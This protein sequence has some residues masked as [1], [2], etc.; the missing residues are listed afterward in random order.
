MFNHLA[1]CDKC[2]GILVI[3][4]LFLTTPTCP[5]NHIMETD[6]KILFCNHFS[7]SDFLFFAV[8]LQ[9]YVSWRNPWQNLSFENKY[10]SKNQALENILFAE[11][12]AWT[13][14]Q[15]CPSTSI[16]ILS[17]N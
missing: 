2:L 15:K 10:V 11:Y 14:K 17:F 5:H 16:S 4:F 3:I 13:A 6:W 8:S 12:T 7:S 9:E 1:F